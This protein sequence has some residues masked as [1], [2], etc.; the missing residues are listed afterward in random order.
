MATPPDS[1]KNS[2]RQR[3]T[4][5]AR[6]HWPQLHELRIRHR[7]AFAYVDGELADGST[8]LLVRGQERRIGHAVDDEGQLPGQVVGVLDAGVAAEA[9][10]RGHHVGRVAGE[11]DRPD[12]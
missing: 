12:R 1:T 8:F 7:G 11:E 9:S 3:L 5:H 4:A 6:A 10:V 2:L